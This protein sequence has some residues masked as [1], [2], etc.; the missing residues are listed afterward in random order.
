M[1]IYALPQYNYNRPSSR[2]RTQSKVH[3]PVSFGMENTL[4]NRQITK[5]A[6]DI[7]QIPYSTQSRFEFNLINFD[8]IARRDLDRLNPQETDAFRT[9]CMSKIM[10]EG[11]EKVEDALRALGEHSVRIM[12]NYNLYREAQVQA[13]TTNSYIPLDDL[14]INLKKR[15]I[16]ELNDG[17]TPNLSELVENIFIKHGLKRS[18]GLVS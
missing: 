13:Q 6:K 16:F 14:A 10:P 1:K 4:S 8:L 5:L 12:D 18:H 3:T 2:Q 15:V 9:L 11:I 17:K 7:M